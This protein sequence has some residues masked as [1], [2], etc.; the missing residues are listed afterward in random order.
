MFNKIFVNMK[1]Y[2]IYRTLKK[3]VL[4]KIDQFFEMNDKTENFILL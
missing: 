1:L 3:A 4:K 2:D